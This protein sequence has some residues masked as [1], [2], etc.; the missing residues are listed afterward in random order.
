MSVGG[1]YK[2]N[3]VATNGSVLGRVM[4]IF[5]IDERVIES[6]KGVIA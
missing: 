3:D 4:I 2:C 6:D 1:G 5:N